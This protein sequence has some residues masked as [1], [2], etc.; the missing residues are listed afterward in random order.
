[1]SDRRPHKFPQ[2]ESV[3]AERLHMKQ[4]MAAAFR[5]FDRFG[6][7]EGVAGHL[8]GRDPEHPD[9]FWVNPLGMS[10]GQIRASDLICVDRKGEV[11]DG[12]WPVNTAAFAIHS[13]VHEARPDVNAA[14]H[15]HS[16]YGRAFSTLGKPLAPLTQDACAFYGDHTVFDD[17][18]GVVLDV[19]EGKRIAHA[20]GGTKACILRNH[21]LLTVGETVDE[22]AW[23]FITMDRSCQ[24]QL[25]ADA[26][27]DPI[28]IDHEHASLTQTQV[29]SHVGGW[30]SFQ[31]LY[32]KIVADQPDLLD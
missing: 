21:G 32:D 7:N 15:T 13:Q 8:T 11:V 22:A 23:W 18:T 9:L 5:L 20:L 24:V 12:D 29:G 25:M 27:G 31:P 16:P 30:F 17:Y 6:F 26:A 3:D 4:R 10:F 1:M 28:P 2:F 14:A 19:E